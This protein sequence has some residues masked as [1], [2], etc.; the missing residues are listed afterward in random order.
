MRTVF[1]SR[2]FEDP[3]L[4]KTI[5]INNEREGWLWWVHQHERR[6]VE[7]IMEGLNCK[8]IWPHRMIYGDFQQI[9]ETIE[10]LGL[11]W[12]TEVLSFID[13]KLWKARNLD[14]ESEVTK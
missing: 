11:K 9:Y 8:V 3:A 2:T 13:P 1:T 4:R 7:M 14:R 10:W 6:F 12:R 5:G